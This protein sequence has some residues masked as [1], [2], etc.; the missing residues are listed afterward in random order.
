[1]K[2]LTKEVILQATGKTA[3][4]GFSPVLDVDI[5]SVNKT[6]SFFQK[7]SPIK[8]GDTSTLEKIATI[9]LKS[10]AAVI[11]ASKVIG[12]VGLLGKVCAKF[13]KRGIKGGTFAEQ[14]YKVFKPQ[15]LV[16]SDMLYAICGVE[17]P[18]KSKVNS[19]DENGG[20]TASL[21]SLEDQNFDT[22]TIK[23]TDMPKSIN[24]ES[25]QKPGVKERYMY[26][27]TLSDYLFENKLATSLK[28]TSIINK[29]NPVTSNIN[30]EYNNHKNLQEMFKKLF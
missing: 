24:I 7:I 19:T 13:F 5:Q 2:T 20:M 30:K 10:D 9:A 8:I 29:K 22:A 11:A 12:P 28:K 6:V 27:N 1:M 16:Y 21:Q 17:I 14:F 26:Q 15:Q 18:G 25:S 4:A 3:Q 23:L